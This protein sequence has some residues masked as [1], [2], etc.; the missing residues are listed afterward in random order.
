MLILFLPSHFFSFIFYIFYE[1]LFSSGGFVQ[2]LGELVLRFAEMA[3]VSWYV[4]LMFGESTF[5]VVVVVVLSS[6]HKVRDEIV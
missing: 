1:L 6:C 5:F 3:R 4:A 2:H